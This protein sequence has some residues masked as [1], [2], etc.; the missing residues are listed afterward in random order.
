M[1]LL[2]LLGRI[3]YS[4]FLFSCHRQA[5]HLIKEMDQDGDGRISEPEV[6]KN[7]E[8]FMNSE[9]TDYGRQLHVSHDEL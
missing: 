7:Q 9:V 4:L 8:I 1:L 2:L 6:L 3:T 5:L